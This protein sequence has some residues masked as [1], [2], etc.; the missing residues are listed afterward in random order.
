MRVAHRPDPTASS[1]RHANAQQVA[2][3]LREPP[4]LLLFPRKSQAQRR[5]PS[6]SLSRHTHT[7]THGTATLPLHGNQTLA[8]FSKIY[9][10]N[11]AHPVPS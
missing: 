5:S 10:P 3:P 6:T 8:L 7:H 2:L 4:L 11:P 1:R 9:K